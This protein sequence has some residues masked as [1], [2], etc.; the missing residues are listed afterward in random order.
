M[1]LEPRELLDRALLPLYPPEPLP[2]A[3]LLPREELVGMLRL[4]ILLLPPLPLRLAAPL[5]P[6][7]R[8]LTLAPLRLA[9]LRLPP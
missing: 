9:L 5:P 7:E 8:S 3:E 6:A 2:N 4:P 1:L